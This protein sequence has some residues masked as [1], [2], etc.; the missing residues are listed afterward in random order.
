MTR[1]SESCYSMISVERLMKYCLYIHVLYRGE[2][3]IYVKMNM[4]INMNISVS[5]CRW[6]P[7]KRALP[8]MLKHGR[9]DPF[10]RIPSMCMYMYIW[11]MS[12]LLTVF[13]IHI[14][15]TIITTRFFWL[16]P[17]SAG[18]QYIYRILICSSL[19]LHIDGFVQDCS[20]SSALAMEILQTCTKPSIYL[21][22]YRCFTV[23]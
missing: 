2:C 15:G 20:I 16:Q 8:A 9:W 22:T 1:F 12:H 13:V 19:W 14:K 5:V 18:L 4:N 6:Y 10:G 11:E 23:R 17:W 21:C 7:A 3:S